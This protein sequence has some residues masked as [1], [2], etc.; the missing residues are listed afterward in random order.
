MC[1]FVTVANICNILLLI[2]N[3]FSKTIKIKL[4]LM[5]IRFCHVK[6]VLTQVQVYASFKLSLTAFKSELIGISGI[7]NTDFRVFF[8]NILVS[9]YFSGIL[10]PR[11]AFFFSFFFLQISGDFK[12]PFSKIINTDFRGFFARIDGRFGECQNLR[13]YFLNTVFR[14]FLAAA[15]S[16]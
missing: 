8:F 1:S 15:G 5:F 9:G 11:F 14:G 3:Q 10:N 2:S 4:I 6:V 12:H 16:R 7:L 13:V